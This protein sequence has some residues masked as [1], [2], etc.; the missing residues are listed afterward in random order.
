MQFNTV[1]I[2]NTATQ[3]L[4]ASSARGGWIIH[5]ASDQD[6]YIGGTSSVTTANG[7]PLASG[8]KIVADGPAAWNGALH[9][10][11]ASGTADL[12]YFE[13]GENDVS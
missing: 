1:T 5:N 7:I 12:R 11:V 6:I 8:E 13:W 3:I 4:G 2:A 10:I 9:G